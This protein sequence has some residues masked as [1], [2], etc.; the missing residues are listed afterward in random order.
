MILR[1]SVT[2][3]YKVYILHIPHD[4]TVLLDEVQPQSSSLSSDENYRRLYFKTLKKVFK[5][6]LK[7]SPLSKNISVEE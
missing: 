3:T 1:Q 5:G 6:F 4:E 2:Y 7:K